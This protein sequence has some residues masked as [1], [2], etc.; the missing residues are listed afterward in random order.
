LKIIINFLSNSVD[1]NRKDR[2][3]R[4]HKSSFFNRQYSIPACPG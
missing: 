3:G 2:G 4:Y 1:L